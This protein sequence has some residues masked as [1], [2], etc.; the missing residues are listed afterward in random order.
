MSSPRLRAAARVWRARTARRRADR[1]YFAYLLVMVAITAI[2]PVARML[3]LKA[4]GPLGSTLLTSAGLPWFLVLVAIVF[5][6]GALLVGSYRGPTLR[7]PSLLHA[8][9]SSDLRYSESLRGALVRAAT[10]TLLVT[11]AVAGFTGAALLHLGLES[12]AGVLV[13]LVAACA[14]GV[15]ATLCGLIGQAHPRAATSVGLIALAAVAAAAVTVIPTPTLNPSGHFLAVGA[16]GLI[17]VAATLAAF[18]PQMLNGLGYERLMQQATN[19]NAA[20]TFSSTLDFSL[21]ATVYQERPRVGRR[22][23][24]V[25]ELRSLPLV[26]LLRDAV[27]LLRTPGRLL[28]AVGASTSVGVLVSLSV[29]APEFRMLLSAGAA[30]L[31]Y[32][33]AGALG[34][35][36]RHAAQV[37]ADYPL[38]G[39]SGRKLVAY[40]CV[41]PLVSA[42]T[43]V[44]GANVATALTTGI[45]MWG[46]VLNGLTLTLLI[47]AIRLGA[48]LRGP[49]PPR[50]LAPI[51][52][53]AGDLSII[54][55]FAWAFEAPLVALLSGMALALLPLTPLPLLAAVTWV[56]VSCVIRW[57]HR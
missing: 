34:Q 54:V 20:V 15:I 23:S 51:E 22:L 53:P 42:V 52:S 44:T 9:L 43:L 2:A 47:L 16:A 45:P 30:L 4:T 29:A 37:A 46:P 12:V 19:W 40:H 55:Q 26:F 32:L 7:S 24:A 28:G 21:A 18:T 50:L 6:A 49:L 3:W 13:L 36:M 11:A 35:G 10:L 38:F 14:V 25:R 33:A 5:W 17:A 8:L 57:R 41:F 48:A 31:L 27:G 56:T 1:G 39:L